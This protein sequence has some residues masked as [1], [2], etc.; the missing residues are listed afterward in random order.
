VAD[1]RLELSVDTLAAAV[2]ADGLGVDRIELCA[3]ALD[4][5]LTPS[6]GV[7]AEA[8]RRCGHAQVHVLVR[9]RGGDFT[10]S[11][12]EVDAMAEDIADA[13]GL[14]AD[15]V[16]SGVLTA[17]GRPD[18]AAMATLVAA[19]GSREFTFHRAIDV[20]ADPRAALAA[21][22]GLGVRRVLTSGSA[23]TAVDGAD[24]IAELVQRAGPALSVMAGG[25][26]RPHNVVAL[27][28]ATGVHD[29]HAAPRRPVVGR[30]GG[31]G[32]VVDFTSGGPPVGYDRY[33]LD[34]DVARTLLDLVR[35]YEHRP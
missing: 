32:S 6:H 17:D 35:G 26:V 13:V 10:Y 33:D 16:V 31:A 29:V 25:G 19:A 7:V 4:G 2:A 15:G 28:D 1:R 34:E 9:P 21:L 5:G 27:L 11:A 18:D 14:G 30:Q 23:L 20:C 22:V 3:A 24:L 8:V 12:A